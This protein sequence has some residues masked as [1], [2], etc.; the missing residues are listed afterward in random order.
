MELLPEGRGVRVRG[1]QTHGKAV[2]KVRAGQRSAVNLAGVDHTEVERGMVLC[3]RG[4]LRPA[5]ILDTEIEV[6]K[7]AKKALRSRQRVRVH[8]GAAEALARVEVLNE[9]G[10]IAQGET[11]LA[12]I[13]LECPVVAIPGDRFIIRSY[14]PQATIAG[15]RVVDG[16]ARKHRRR[17]TETARVFLKGLM[18]ADRVSGIGHF[19]E[20]AGESGLGFADLQARTGWRREVLQGAIAAGIEKRSVIEAEGFYIARTPFDGLRA[21][22]TAAIEAHHAR[23]PLARGIL[24][25]GLREKVFRHTSLDVFKAVLTSLVA[26]GAIVQESETI[27]LASHSLELAGDEKALYDRLKK[28]YADARFEVPSSMMR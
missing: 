13:R 27:R 7:D 22:V 1:L 26:E 12:Q 25:E 14:S 18:A 10:E 19:L 17:D 24:R 8:I 4:V 20:D 28:I 23:E 3:E 2:K 6:L 15:G 16:L 9:A 21:K 11:D 5:Q